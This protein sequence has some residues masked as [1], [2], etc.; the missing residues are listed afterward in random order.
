MICSAG[1]PTAPKGPLTVSDLTSNSCKLSWKE[2][3]S[4][5]GKPL[6]QYIIERR[7]SKR[8]S[9]K[10][11]ETVRPKY[12]SID[13]TRL[14]EGVEYEFRVFAENEEGRSPALETK[15][16]TICRKSACKFHTVLQSS[17]FRNRF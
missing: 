8:Y 3:E 15:D 14:Q 9:W 10:E 17:A 6:K 12:T 11:V 2:P 16:K 7:D 13:V 5:G 1:P 4:D